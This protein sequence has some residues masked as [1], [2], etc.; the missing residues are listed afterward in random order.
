MDHILKSLSTCSDDSLRLKILILLKKFTFYKTSR[1]PPKLTKTLTFSSHQLS[2][3]YRRNSRELES[4]RKTDP[5]SAKK[6]FNWTTQSRSSFYEIEGSLLIKN[7]FN[8]LFEN[9]RLTQWI[10]ND[11]EKQCS[12][13]IV[14][15]FFLDCFVYE[16]L[17]LNLICSPIENKNWVSCEEF[18]DCFE[19]IQSP[20]ANFL[21]TKNRVISKKNG[22]FATQKLICKV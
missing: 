22:N 6:S 20:N 8:K 19:N 13:L 9:Y 5:Y 21:H 10:K 11:L 15:Q 7:V 12:P 17:F 4:R 1:S 14:K 16:S 3:R 2:S 18:H